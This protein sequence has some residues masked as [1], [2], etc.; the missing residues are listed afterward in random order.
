MSRWLLVMP[1]AGDNP[2]RGHRLGI[3][4]LF[5]DRGF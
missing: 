4:D 5:W 3:V 1:E 2:R